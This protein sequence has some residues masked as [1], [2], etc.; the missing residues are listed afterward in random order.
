MFRQGAGGVH[1]VKHQ[2]GQQCRQGHGRLAPPARRHGRHAVRGDEFIEGSQ[3]ELVRTE[4]A[5]L[6]KPRRETRYRLSELL[7]IPCTSAVTG[8]IEIRNLVQP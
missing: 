4:A 7:R 6:V 5:V 3:V 8:N 1:D 2:A